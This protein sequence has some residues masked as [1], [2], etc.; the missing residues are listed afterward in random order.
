MLDLAKYGIADKWPRLAKLQGEI[1]DLELAR[2][3]AQ[4]EVMAANGGSFE[5]H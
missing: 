3:K 4:G 1:R 5:P 2:A